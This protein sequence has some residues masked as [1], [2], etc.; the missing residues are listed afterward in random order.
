M[1]KRRTKNRTKNGKRRN[2][3]QIKRKTYRKIYNKT[4]KGGMF[5]AL[6]KLVPQCLMPRSLI[7]LVVARWRLIDPDN[8]INWNNDETSND[9]E[10]FTCILRDTNK[11]NLDKKIVGNFEKK[12][13]SEFVTRKTSGESAEDILQ[14]NSKY[15]SIARIFT[16]EHKDKIICLLTDLYKIFKRINHDPPDRDYHSNP[17]KRHY[18]FTLIDLSNYYFEWYNNI[19]VENQITNKDGSIKTREKTANL[20]SVEHGSTIGSTQYGFRTTQNDEN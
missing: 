9:N 10:H 14:S 8:N 7:H 11:F 19:N 16:H 17:E 5:R 18:R 3:K 13:Y 2:T 20:D 15:D 1:T 4:K 6:G 12:Q